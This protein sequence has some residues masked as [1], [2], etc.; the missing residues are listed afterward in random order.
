MRLYF[1][2]LWLFLDPSQL[3]DVSE[4]NSQVLEQR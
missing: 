3:C 1:A 2:V 4:I